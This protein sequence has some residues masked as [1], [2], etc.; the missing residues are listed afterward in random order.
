VAIAVDAGLYQEADA[1]LTALGEGN[2]GSPVIDALQRD[3]DARRRG[4]R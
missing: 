4:P 2:A 1:A 3:L